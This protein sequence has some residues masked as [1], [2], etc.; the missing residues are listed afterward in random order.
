MIYQPMVDGVLSR[1][2]R[3]WYQVAFKWSRLKAAKRILRQRLSSTGPMKPIDKRRER[4]ENRF[5][6]CRKAGVSVQRVTGAH[7]AIGG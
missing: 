4:A 2:D 5:N 1:I 7:L 3:T 6:C